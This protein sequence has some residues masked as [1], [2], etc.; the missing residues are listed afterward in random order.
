MID[1]SSSHRTDDQVDFPLTREVPLDAPSASPA[2]VR[3]FGDY[4]LQ[5]E[6][7][8]GGMGIVYRA[9]QIS[10]NRTVALKMI[11]ADT[12][13]S[14]VQVERF[15][16]E[17]EAAAGLDHPHIVPIY[18]VGEHDSH[19]YF[20][21]KLVVGGNLSKEI[22]QLIQ[23]PRRVAGLL[24]TVAEAVH[25][26]HQRGILH[27]DLKP[28][29]ILL[30]TEGQPYVTDFGLAKRSGD[31]SKTQTGAVLGTPSYMPPEQAVGRKDLS[32]AA[33]VYSLGAI[34]YE[35]LTGR[36]P[37]KGEST[38]DTLLLVQH[39]EPARPHTLNPHV[40]RD[41]ETICLKCL[42]K[43]P[44]QRYTSALEL[45]E[46]LRAFLDDKPIRARPLS[47][48]ERGVKWCR[49]NR[50]LAA[51]LVVSVVTVVAIGILGV[52]LY[53][54]RQLSDAL[55]AAQVERDNAEQQ[56]READ[57]QRGE[58]QRQKDAAEAQRQEADRQRREADRQR[59][60]VR[61]YQYLAEMN[62]AQAEWQHG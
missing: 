49:R 56:R 29:N 15:R 1:P 62:L 16:L 33:D 30:D 9:Q 60:L 40:S 6:I 51:L 52:G 10:L 3:Y 14:S 24:A 57:R 59:A 13:A 43:E 61:P 27:R 34:L 26:A 17:A 11:L 12:F 55:A 18:E 38:L 35:C 42:E 8:R 28:A 32:T 37:F 54:G 53:Y 22:P 20:S 36:P 23:N 4:A 47:S 19:P 45:A 39:Q 50:T 48:W 58:A 44:R 25:H 5:E 7:A 31:S 2:T 21:M 41:L 46:D